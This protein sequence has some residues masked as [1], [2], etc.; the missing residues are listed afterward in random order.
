MISRKSVHLA[1]L[2]ITLSDHLHV[3][4]KNHFE[5]PVLWPVE[6]RQ[7]IASRFVRIRIR[8]NGFHLVDPISWHHNITWMQRGIHRTSDPGKDDR[9]K[10]KTVDCH[11]GRQCG[12]DHT[13]PRQKKAEMLAVKIDQAYARSIY[14]LDLTFSSFRDDSLFCSR[15]FAIECRDDADAVELCRGAAKGQKRTD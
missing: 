2:R 3:I 6:F 9:I 4:R 10:W 7:N 13:H 1:E 8:P 5:V 12:I 15:Q 11:L 14:F